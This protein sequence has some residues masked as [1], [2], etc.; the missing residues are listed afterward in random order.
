MFSFFVSFCSPPL[1]VIVLLESRARCVCSELMKKRG[2]ADVRPL[3]DV[4]AWVRSC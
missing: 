3:K 1:D 2:R 4:L